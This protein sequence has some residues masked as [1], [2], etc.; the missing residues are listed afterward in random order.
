M[1]RVDDLS[2]GSGVR[3]QIHIGKLLNHR[4]SREFREKLMI[5]SGVK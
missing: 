4:Y 1:T 2:L 5:Y 3:T